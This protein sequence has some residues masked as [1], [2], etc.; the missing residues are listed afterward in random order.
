M[1]VYTHTDIGNRRSENQDSFETAVL[2]DAVFAVVCDGM[3]G[4][5]A[6]KEASSRAAAIIRERVE[7]SYR[8]DYDSN[9]IRNLLV[10]AVKTANAVVYDLGSAVPEWNG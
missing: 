8:T 10:A 2:E 1:M 5:N 7:K 6:G 4:S 9:K 3:G